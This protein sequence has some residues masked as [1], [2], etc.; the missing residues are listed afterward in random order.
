MAVTLVAGDNVQLV[1]DGFANTLTVHTVVTGPFLDYLFSTTPSEPPGGGQA[2]LDN[3]T[4]TSATKVWLHDTTSPGTAVER[5]L[6]TVKS[7]SSIVMQD[8]DDSTKYLKFT[9]SGTPVDKTTYWEF[10]VTL[11]ASGTALSAQRVLVYLAP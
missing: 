7:G 9:V 3:A 2:R 11:A 8:K 10:P 1:L 4:Q 6:G 5:V